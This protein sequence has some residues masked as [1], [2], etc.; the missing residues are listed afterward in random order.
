MLEKNNARQGFLDHAKFLTLREVLLAYLKD[1]VTFLYHPGRDESL[2]GWETSE[3]A[4]KAL[5]MR[6][7]GRKFPKNKDGR[8]L[9]LE[10]N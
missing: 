6:Y 1:P 8:L 7:S 4:G 5:S 2:R 3:L 9:P 10:G